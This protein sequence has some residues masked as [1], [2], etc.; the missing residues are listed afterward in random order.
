[1]QGVGGKFFYGPGRNDRESD[2]GVFVTFEFPGRNHPKAGKGGKDENDV[3]VGSGV[4][5]TAPDA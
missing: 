1:M 5:A 3:V 2:D 4:I